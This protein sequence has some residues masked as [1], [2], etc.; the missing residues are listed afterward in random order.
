MTCLINYF[1][2]TQVLYT[3]GS[4]ANILCWTPPQRVRVFHMRVVIHFHFH[5]QDTSAIG[6]RKGTTLAVYTDA[7]SSDEDG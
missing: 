6:S 3:G 4:D 7:W 1:L 5:F 2:T